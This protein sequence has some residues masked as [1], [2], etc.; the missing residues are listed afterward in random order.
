MFHDGIIRGAVAGLPAHVFVD[1]GV[2]GKAQVELIGA[3]AR[4]DAGFRASVV[5][6]GVA[7]TK[8]PPFHDHGRIDR[9]IDQEHTILPLHL[10]VEDRRAGAPQSHETEFQGMIGAQAHEAFAT[11]R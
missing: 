11:H 3:D 10:F 7:V 4:S 2:T 9:G 1:D 5:D 6:H 8:P